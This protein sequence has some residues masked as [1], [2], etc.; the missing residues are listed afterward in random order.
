MHSRNY[1]F[2]YSCFSA[3]FIRISIEIK[4]NNFVFTGACRRCVV[5]STAL[6]ARSHYNKPL[7]V[8]RSSIG[9]M[10]TFYALYAY[11]SLD[12]RDNLRHKGQS[13][14][15][16]CIQRI[17]AFLFYCTVCVYIFDIYCRAM[18]MRASCVRHC[19][20]FL[21]KNYIKFSIFLANGDAV[22]SQAQRE[23]APFLQAAESKIILPLPFSP[24][25]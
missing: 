21:R 24:L 7:G 10:S 5:V 4:I 23:A 13:R 2:I 11:D 15:V 8:W 12:A 1:L 3:F 20:Y 18:Y 16:R 17:M 14:G 6:P 25:Q 22:W 9:P 19:S